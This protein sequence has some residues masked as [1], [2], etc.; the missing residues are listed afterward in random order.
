[1]HFILIPID[2]ILFWLKCFKK[3]VYETKKYLIFAMQFLS[4]LVLDV[5][6][7]GMMR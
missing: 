6:Q 1:M 4:K 5:I 2:D 3:C 7:D